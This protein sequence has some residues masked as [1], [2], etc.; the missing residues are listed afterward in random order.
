MAD[1]C[2]WM[3]LGSVINSCKC[4]LALCVF[5]DLV[6]F[7]PSSVWE[8]REVSYAFDLASHNLGS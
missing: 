1:N 4:H 6:L 8:F 2:A 3:A 5:L 7:F